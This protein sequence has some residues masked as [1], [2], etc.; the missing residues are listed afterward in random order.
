M[1]GAVLHDV[2]DS[3]GLQWTYSKQQLGSTDKVPI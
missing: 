2:L 3:T 1:D